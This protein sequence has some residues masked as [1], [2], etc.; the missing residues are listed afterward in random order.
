MGVLHCKEEIKPH[1]VRYYL[2]RRDAEYEQKMARHCKLSDDRHRA[3]CGSLGSGT[4][5][6]G[7]FAPHLHRRSSQ[8]AMMVRWN[9]VA[10]NV[11]QVGDGIVGG[12]EALKLSG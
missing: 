6:T 5:K 7:D 11:K 2:E 4:L 1:K 8:L 10:R 12:E 3:V 9:V